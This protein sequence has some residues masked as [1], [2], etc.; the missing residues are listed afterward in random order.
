M[1]V[2]RGPRVPQTPFELVDLG[3]PSRLATADHLVVQAGPGQELLV[4]HEDRT[5]RHRADGEL[6]V[7]RIADLAHH[8]HVERSVELGRDR[9]GHDHAASRQPEHQEVRFAA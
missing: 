7:P 8:E 3:Q 9:R 6:L 1:Q 5:A 2:G 4:A